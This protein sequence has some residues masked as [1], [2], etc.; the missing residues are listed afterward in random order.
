MA[1]TTLKTSS[2]TTSYRNGG[3]LILESFTPGFVLDTFQLDAIRAIDDGHNVLVCAPTGSGKTVVGEYAIHK[4]RAEGKKCFYTTPIKALS[5]QK[6]HDLV[7]EHGVDKVGLLTGDVS[8]H[9]EAEIVVMTTEVLRNMI[10][11][12]SS[13]LDELGYVVTDEIHYLADP[14]RGAIWE[15][16]ILNLDPEVILIGLSAT[17]SNYEEFG[18]WLTAVRGDTEVIVSDHRPVP[19]KDYMV[20]GH[21]L[22]PLFTEKGQLNPRVESAI[23]HPGRALDRPRI[24]TALAQRNLLPAIT[25]IFSRAGCDAAVLQCMRANVVL[26]D[27]ETAQAIGSY[28]DEHTSELTVEEKR[29]LGLAR[30]R[31]CLMR[32]FAAHHAGMLP[33]L[34]HIVEHLFSEGLLQAVFATETL[35]LGINMPA[36]TVVLEKLVKFNGTAHV[37][38]TPGQYT[39]MTGRAGRRGKDDNGF[40]LIEWSEHMDLQAVSELACA[41]SVPLTSTFQP[42]Y[43][44]ALNLLNTHSYE[45]SVALIERSFA[46]F[47]VDHSVVATAQRIEGLIRALNR[48]EGELEEIL[49][50]NVDE[51]S[52]PELTA[53][54]VLEYAD[55]RKVLSAA[56]K[57]SRHDSVVQHRKEIDT[58]LY[59]LHRGDVVALPGRKHPILAVV[60][61]AAEKKH[62]PRPVMVLETGWSGRIGST[63]IAMV[64]ISVG[65]MRLPQEGRV[66]SQKLQRIV[67]QQFRQMNYER[68]RK[69]RQRPRSRGSARVKAL[70]EELNHHPVHALSKNQRESAVYLAHKILRQRSDL[71]ALRE[72]EADRNTLG[73]SFRRIVNLL[74]ELGYVEER[75]EE[76]VVGSDSTTPSMT[77]VTEEGRRLANIHGRNDLLISQCLRRG[78]WDDL[79]PAQLAGLV[80]TC[81]FE[82]RKNTESQPQLADEV[83]THAYSRTYR[84]WEELVSDE[85]RYMLPRTQAP[86]AGLALA[87]H[88]WTA[89][90][91]LPYCIDAAKHCGVELTPGDFVRH[92]RQVIDMLQQIAHEGYSEDIRDHAYSAVGAIRRGVVAMAV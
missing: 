15:E 12:G 5:N 37:D 41:P 65:R 34:R 38:L 36:R 57:E 16:V 62:N 50:S 25:F 89:G 74:E 43:N 67:A 84:V 13:T 48:L 82:S 29:V 52:S 27:R 60:I 72:R 6:Y 44:M 3:D 71:A 76:Q 77:C 40:A 54:D 14:E 26:T 21:K 86:D 33:L 1:T 23:E 7:A 70:R 45:A 61:H 64:P 17:V 66:R 32:G 10:Y 4:A 78:L 55:M 88:Q 30:W 47:H 49:H 91:P 92:A 2:K 87:I 85:D 35:A 28:I 22:Y 20:V 39:Q 42:N 63:D 18:H 73:H 8:V 24:L 9:A 90:A 51:M 58:I 46:Q 59:R 83:M 80:S 53:D 11:A 69:M 79:D 68:P 75:S 81:T 31:K 19:L 56:E